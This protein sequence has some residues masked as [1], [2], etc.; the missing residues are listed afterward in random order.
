MNE[1]YVTRLATFQ[2][3]DFSTQPEKQIKD[4]R[5]FLK[6]WRLKNENFLLQT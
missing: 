1:K 3:K 6:N 4:R 2:R 5:R